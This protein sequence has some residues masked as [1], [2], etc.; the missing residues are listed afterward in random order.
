M[1]QLSVAL[2]EARRI[3]KQLDRQDIDEDDRRSE[4]IANRLGADKVL[5]LD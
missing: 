1:E 3:E 2:D 4:E 5:A